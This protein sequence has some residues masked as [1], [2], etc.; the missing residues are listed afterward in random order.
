[1]QAGDWSFPTVIRFGPGRIAE[2]PEVLALLRIER[3]LLV[4]DE[5][6]APLPMVADI[7][8]QLERAG[9]DARLYGEVQG[10]PT[11]SNVQGG[12]ELLRGEDR[13]GVIALGGGSAL[14]AGKTIAMMARQQRPLWEYV[15]GDDA[16]M[17]VD[18]KAIAPVVAIPTTA[19]TG[20]EV[21]RA[22]VILD[23]EAHQKKIVWHPGMLPKMVISDPQLT[24]GLP[25][26]I[27]AW[28]G[29]DAMVH[30]I[31]AVCSPAYHPMA[32]GIG[33]EAIRRVARWLPA[34]V[35]D[36]TDIEAR[37]NMLV[38]ASMGATAF[39]KG[40]G[41][42][43]SISHVVGAFYNTHHGLTNAVVLPF[44]LTQNLSACADKLA[45]LAAVLN[46]EERSAGGFIDYIYALR[47]QLGIP[48]SL[49]DIGVDD[50]RAEEIGRLAFDDPSTPS[51]ARPVDAQ[52]LERLFL[53]AQSGDPGRL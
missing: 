48:G 20:S 16:W 15:D 49:S 41:S 30:A 51:N 37:G 6:L 23:E 24:I 40:L 19:G 34:A 13:D 35:A 7:V 52:D 45:H 9:I 29:I 21:G 18:P 47:E 22:A 25:P 8:G 11:A 42:V 43:H 12:L 2:L 31:E 10:N 53:A 1:M 39:Q 33:I 46:L 36:G 27:T 38:A 44:G 50:A 32:E 5:G 3:P 14:D 4:T 26:N 17:H 28:T